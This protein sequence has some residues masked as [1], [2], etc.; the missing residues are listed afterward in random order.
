M[1]H[2][3]NA[4]ENYG[5]ATLADVVNNVFTDADGASVGNQALRLNS[6]AL[7][8]VT[9]AGIAGT[10]LVINDGI[11]AFQSHRDLVV[12]LTGY[13]SPFPGLGDIDNVNSFFV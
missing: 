8:N 4:K 11:P 10:Y 7:V 1:P 2:L 5:V 3:C 6:T 9:T 12:N 13:T